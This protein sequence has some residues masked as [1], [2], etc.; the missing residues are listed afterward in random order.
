MSVCTMLLIIVAITVSWSGTPIAAMNI[1]AIE[2]LTGKSHWNFMSAL[3]RAL[4]DS[5][6]RVTAF[7]PLPGG[8]R[9]NYTEI[10]IS[11]EISAMDVGIDSHFVLENFRKSS[12]MIP[13][14]MNWTRCICDIINEHPKMKDILN[15]EKSGYD[16]IIVE[17][18]ASEC[19]TYVATKLNV[20]IIFSS[21]SPLKTTIEY[22]LIGNGP[23]PATV[24]HVMAYHSVPRTF[25]QRFTNSLF[26]VYSTFL[27]TRK[28]SEMKTNNPGEYDLME[29]VKP[30]IVFLNTYYV[31]EAPRPFPP[32]VIQVGGI[33][34]QPPED[35]II[36]AD[37]L[38]FIDNSPYGVIYFTFGSIVEMST[39]P[40]HI[41]NAYKDGLS[42]VPQRVLWKYDGEMKNKP[43][44][45]MTRKWFP[46]REILLHPKIKLFISHGGISGVYEAIDASVPILGLPVFYDQPRNIEHL[47]D[48]GMAISMDL[49]SVTKYNFLNAVNDLINNE[50][51]RKNANIV[52]KH[53]KDRPMTP[54]RSVVYWTE[55]VY[56][57]KSAHH[58]KSYAFNLTW[59]QYYLL[60]VIAV[61][62]LLTVS[63]VYI[64]YKTL[65]YMWINNK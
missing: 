48:A 54:V 53:F 29:Q 22:S 24:S 3:L 19:V 42:Q 2:P 18:A 12:V 45:V 28:E 34:L 41:Q 5:G 25:F 61:I 46:Q 15:S 44:N 52:S 49:L 10:D 27:S 32:N 6:H 17:R 47:V 21:P 26:F 4:T 39:L 1:L 51:Y 30:S 40:D 9:I 37:I 36:P 58:L 56:H 57:H 55:Y 20:P 14:V 65:V 59:Y 60:D 63:T 8:E 16:L 33:H 64:T 62:L 35:N 23:N 13:L 50:K 11:K 31:T 7:T 38:E 43:T